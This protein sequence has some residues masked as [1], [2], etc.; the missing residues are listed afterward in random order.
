MFSGPHNII[1]IS[2]ID[3]DFVWQ[4]HQEIM[5]TLASQGHRVLFIENTGVRNVTLKDLSR[6]KHRF[7]NWRRGIKGI[8][9]VMDNL[10]VYAPLV[11][12]FPYSQAAC[13]VNKAIMHWTLKSW[14]RTM[15]F[16]NP[17]IW[18][19][20]PT[21]LSLELIRLLDA[22]LVIYYCCDN[23]EASSPTARRI[24][25]S[26]DV[27][28]RMA[29]L[30]FAHSRALY[31]RCIR[32]TDQVHL[33]QYGYNREI[34]ARAN[35]DPPGDLA[36]I[37]RPIIGYIGGIHQRIDL[38]LLE[39]VALH[40]PDKSLVFVGP[41]QTDIARIKSLPNVHFLGQKQYE[42]LPAYIRHFDIGLIPYMLSEYT[43][44]VYPTKLNE[45][46][47]MGKPVVSTRL[48]EVEWF[49]RSHQDVVSLADTQEEFSRL[50]QKE[51]DNDN[52]SLRARR[53]EAVEKNAWPEK[54]DAMT[55]LAQAKLDEKIKSREVNWQQALLRVYRGSRRTIMSGA[56]AGVLLYGLLV[57]TPLMWKLGEPLRFA[58]EPEKAD[59]ILVLAGGIGESGVPG[60][61]YQE[62][63]K[64]GVE[65]FH[66]QYANNLIF[67]SGAGYVFKEAQVMKAL[68]VSLGVPPKAI[69]L[70]ERGGGNYSALV[71]AK[72]ILVSRGW[73]RML[74]VT[75]RYNTMRSRLVAQKNLPEISVHFTPAAHSAFF[76]DVGPIGWKQARAIIHEYRAIVYYWAKGMI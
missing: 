41:L 51:L 46:L 9:K 40:H 66:Q 1:C 20:L 65:L 56:I 32:L 71:N 14:T 39:H 67:S 4:G 48:P 21:A 36:A 7:W 10:Y 58:D 62:K 50:I 70:E 34:F 68:A 64:Q 57:H 15:R 16:D 28:I 6:L 42:E 8:R 61:A 75:S 35:A 38:E 74:V 19:W 63:V 52:D 29:D 47:V 69:I 23:F 72:D 13:L 25:E 2:T 26:E 30:V 43:R 12:P 59:V 37:V 22:P 18:T 60:E 11:L 73:T 45:Y 5:S 27:L 33:F 17:L 44:N 31:E 49:N 24:H 54:I 76:G 3:W 53:I 55:S